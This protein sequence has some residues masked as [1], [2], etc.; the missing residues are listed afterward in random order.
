M[1]LQGKVVVVTGAGQGIGRAI[2]VS[3]AASGAQLALID[4][5][6]EALETS[7]RACM[8]HGVRAQAYLANVADEAAVQQAFTDIERDFGR[9]DGLVNNA[10]ILR[11]ALLVKVKDGAVV[12]A[13]SLQQWQ[14]VI[15]VDLTGV[16]LCGRE[17]ASRMVRLGNGGVIVNLSSVSRHG[18]PGQSNYSAAKAGVAAMSVVW[19]KE[20]GRYGI[21][22]GSV[23]PGF[24]RTEILSGMKPDVLQKVLAPVP[25]K[26]L[27]EVEEIAQAVHFIFDNDF[28]TGR[29][30]DIDGGLSL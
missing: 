8:E 28:F 23:A 16:F 24:T 4:L 5:N 10:G 29:C 26:R 3:L 14:A 30:I 22:A 6:A 1:N 15:D 19:A 11:D 17:A 12:G 2:A 7:C 25:L 13:M 21:R 20:L 27:G 18:N 9:L